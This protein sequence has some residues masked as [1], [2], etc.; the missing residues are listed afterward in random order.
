MPPRFPIDAFGHVSHPRVILKIYP[1]IERGVLSQVNGI[2]VHQT[3]GATANST[4]NEYL[5]PGAKGAHFLIDKDGTIYQTASV[6]KVAHHVGQ[7]QSRCMAELRCTPDTLNA[8]KGKRAGKGIGRVEAAK[9]WPDR[10][11]GNFDSLGIEIVGQAVPRPGTKKK[12]FDFEPLTD[13]QQ[14]SLQ[15]LVQQ[16]K[17]AFGVRTTEIF[18][19][20]VVSWKQ[21]SEAASARW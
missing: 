8:L 9:A 7:L 18:R 10:Y 5:V 12:V 14:S 21:L 16:L 1:L 13:A 20:P 2:I 6:H 3:G 4:F 15:W 11:P 17:D 19:H